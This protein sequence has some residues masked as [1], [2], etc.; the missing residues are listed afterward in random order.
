MSV[1]CS[2]IACWGHQDTCKPCC[3]LMHQANLQMTKRHAVFQAEALLTQPQIS[4]PVPLIM[5]QQASRPWHLP[6]LRWETVSQWLGCRHHRECNLHSQIAPSVT[7]TAAEIPTASCLLYSSFVRY[8]HEGLGVSTHS[9]SCLG[10]GAQCLMIMCV[11]VLVCLC[12]DK[13][14]WMVYLHKEVYTE[15]CLI[16]LAGNGLQ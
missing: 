7:G 14:I 10:T 1:S 5:L 4:K 12:C 2:A 8:S 6:S 3:D 15:R 9:G 16:F 13:Q 11:S